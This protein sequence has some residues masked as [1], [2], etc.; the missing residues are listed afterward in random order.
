[1]SIAPFL[2]Q[3][4]SPTATSPE[5]HW[6]RAN[7]YSFTVLQAVCSVMARMVSLLLIT[8]QAP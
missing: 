3:A 8:V 7:L 4:E 2:A 5:G 1:M 6:Q